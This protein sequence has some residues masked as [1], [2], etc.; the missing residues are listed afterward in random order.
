[1]IFDI[2][3]TNVLRLRVGPAFLAAVAKSRIAPHQA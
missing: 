1:M 3:V 2:A